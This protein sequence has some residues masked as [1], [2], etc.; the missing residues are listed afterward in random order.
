MS[1]AVLVCLNRERGISIKSMLSG[2][3]W[4]LAV[5][6]RKRRLD[7]QPFERVLFSDGRIA[8]AQNGWKSSLAFMCDGDLFCTL[9]DS[10]RERSRTE[11]NKDAFH[12]QSSTECK[13][14]L[15]RFTASLLL[16]QTFSQVILCENPSTQ[17][18][19][20]IGKPYGVKAG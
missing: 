19:T 5:P 17:P 18:C 12:T 6:P 20:R 10:K 16:L 13:M 1:E 14:K 7:F 3:K 8:G 11:L 2:G 15:V 4:H 9:C